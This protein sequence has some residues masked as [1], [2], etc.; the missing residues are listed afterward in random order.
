MKYS[1]LLAILF[2]LSLQSCYD[3]GDIRVRNSISNVEITSVKWGDHT[4]SYS[5]LPGQTSQEQTIRKSDEKL[6]A[7]HRVTFIM[8]ANGKMVY[9]ETEEEFSLD[10]DEDLLIILDDETQVYNSN[11]D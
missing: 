8:R 2:T 3:P 9:L 10:Q 1:L 11:S 4:L 6:P 7:T 5:L